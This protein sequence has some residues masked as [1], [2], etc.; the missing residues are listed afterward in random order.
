MKDFENTLKTL[1]RDLRSKRL[2]PLVAILLVAI[3]VVP[4][5]LGSG[6]PP[7][8]PKT[9]LAVGIEPLAET[10]PVVLPTTPELRNFHKRLN[11]YDKKNPFHQ[12]EAPVVRNSSSDPSGADATTTATDASTVTSTDTSS[13]TPTDTSSASG[14]TATTPSST[15]TG[16][17]T[18]P[19]DAGTT[20][21]P[22]DQGA[23][24]S[25]GTDSPR[26]AVVSYDIDVLVGAVG[27]EKEI[28]GAKSLQLLPG[29]SHPVLQYVTT[30]LGGQRASFVTSSAVSS[31]EGD[32]RCAPSRADCQFLQLSVGDSEK[33]VYGP[34][35]RTY[36]IKLLG[37]TQQ[38]DPLRSVGDA[39]GDVS[40]RIGF[41]AGLPSDG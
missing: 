20:T 4:M 19:P 16:A 41:S 13:S 26:P 6:S 15:D 31:V 14:D 23:K 29:D 7:V 3:I 36:R 33:L 39:A 8:A 35:S 1:Y 27:E 2:L 11:E 30:D 37:I 21:T 10:Q 9:E 40:G 25:D 38:I 12:P 22:A 24:P 5:A 17:I 34:T 28:D 18:T 32:G